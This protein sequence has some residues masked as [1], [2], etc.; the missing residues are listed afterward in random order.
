HP[1]HVRV[2][3]LHQ[4][5]RVAAEAGHELVVPAQGRVEVLDRLVRARLL[6]RGQE[7]PAGAAAA[8]RPYVPVTRDHVQ[9]PPRAAADPVSTVSPEFAVVTPVK[10]GAADQYHEMCL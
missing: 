8:D 7:D 6:V 3:D 5:R 2:L 9:N 10:G 1:H 4:L